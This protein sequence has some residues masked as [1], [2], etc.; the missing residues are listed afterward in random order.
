MVQQPKR[1][2]GET[3]P[4]PDAD[5]PMR[6][7]RAGELLDAHGPFGSGNG[8]GMTGGILAFLDWRKRRQARKNQGT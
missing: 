3:N 2:P 7:V 6:T 4:E 1:R 8:L 5:A